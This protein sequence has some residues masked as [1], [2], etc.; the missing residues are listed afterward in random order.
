MAKGKCEFT[1]EDLG[2]HGTNVSKWLT[3]NCAKIG[4]AI[5]ALVHEDLVGSEGAQ[6]GEQVDTKSYGYVGIVEWSDYKF[7]ELFA[8]VAAP[9]LESFYGGRPAAELT[10]IGF[11]R[12][13]TVKGTGGSDSFTNIY[14]ALQDAKA[15]HESHN[16]MQIITQ[17]ATTLNKQLTTAE[18]DLKAA[19]LL[20]KAL[21]SSKPSIINPDEASNGWLAGHISGEVSFT[22]GPGNIPSIEYLEQQVDNIGAHIHNTRLAVDQLLELQKSW[23]AM[24]DQNAKLAEKIRAK[25]QFNMDKGWT[26]DED[27]MKKYGK[28]CKDKLNDLR[29]LEKKWLDLK[30]NASLS[31]KLFTETAAKVLT[32]DQAGAAITRPFKEQ[33]LLPS[34]IYKLAQYKINY[35]EDPYGDHNRIAK[36]LPYVESAIPEG[37]NT[38]S[39][40]GIPPVPPTVGNACLMAQGNPW[41]FINKLTQ[42]SNY[43]TLLD[44]PNSY[45]S[46]LAPKISLFKVV[47]AGAGASEGV[48]PITFDT[49][50]DSTNDLENIFKNQDKRGFGVGLKSFNFSYEGS[51]PF[52][53]KKSIKAKL[54]IF[55]SSFDD[56]LVD[57]GGW[58]YADLALKTGG[59]LQEFLERS[60]QTADAIVANVTKL[61]FRLR[62]VVGWQ[63]PVGR[64]EG[65]NAAGGDIKNA[66]TPLQKA[67]YNSFVT[68]N[69]TPTIHEFDIDDLGRVVFTIN[70][71]A[72]VEDFFDQPNFNIFANHKNYIESMKRKMKIA[73]WNEGCTPEQARELKE[74]EAEKV[75]KEKKENLS[76]VLGH[77]LKRDKIMFL[78]IPRTDLAQFNKKGPYYDI[79]LV[80]DKPEFGN[81]AAADRIEK[82]FKKALS[83]TYSKFKDGKDLSQTP[84]ANMNQTEYVSFFYVSDLVDIVLENIELSLDK[85]IVALTNESAPSE[86]SNA[87]KHWDDLKAVELERLNR[88]KFNFKHFRVVLGPVELFDFKT[89]AG[90]PGQLRDTN[91]GDVPISVSYFMDWLTQKVLSKDVTVYTLPNF[92]ND[93]FNGLVRTFLNNDTCYDINIKQ[94]TRVFQSVVTSYAWQKAEHDE[95]TEYILARRKSRYKS[96]KITNLSRLLVD[97]QPFQTV[98][99]VPVRTS[100][101]LNTMG[102][103]DMPINKRNPALEYNYLIYYAGRT[104]PTERMEGD[105]GKDAA[106]GIF[107]YMIGKPDGLVKT[108]K[109]TRTDSPGLPEVRFEQEGYDGLAQLRETYDATIECY[110]SPNIVPGT[111]IYIDPRGFA[112]KDKG[113]KGQYTFKDRKGNTVVIDRFL[114]TRYGIGGYYMVIRTENNLAPGEF[115]TTITAKWVAELGDPK[116]TRPYA[117]PR[118]SKCAVEKPDLVSQ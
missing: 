88:L 8:K 117:G 6:F 51:N 28:P 17:A 108:I 14:K 40:G 63:M 25:L 89:G 32:P 54:V 52:A 7:K 23:Q 93:L 66:G 74:K 4:E 105:K 96:K 68:L 50:Y 58:R 34:N 21:N 86:L 48:Q 57:R 104:Q 78:P 76:T 85:S 100:G 60:N 67:V 116:D 37:F 69:L 109:L 95:I 73:A 27:C 55:A 29:E 16:N 103:R 97:E 94:K 49:H 77:L 26:K 36:K 107:H 11:H 24:M 47:S 102:V 35:L 20:I 2:E 5:D 72:Y 18:D 62:A 33:C 61:N 9:K 101:I 82:D 1:T 41:G 92:L 46:Q 3:D 13:P 118:P 19:K 84:I 30:M 91:L 75:E 87:K 56:L 70:Y 38:G 80:S 81:V 99:G 10:S 90:G 22:A 64:W 114:L 53:V 12:V 106:S 43:A 115:N 83:A 15:L 65:G 111:Y 110:G 42:D 112:P 39:A 71:L 79:P 113:T 44:I 31:L 98:K 45:L 59:N